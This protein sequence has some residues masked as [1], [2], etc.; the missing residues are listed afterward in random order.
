MTT[1]AFGDMRARAAD[2]KCFYIIDR[3]VARV[4]AEPFGAILDGDRVFLLD[5]V[6]QRKTMRTAQLFIDFLLKGNF[7]R[8]DVIIAVGG[9]ITQDICS[10]VSSMMFRGVDWVFYPTTLLAQADSCIGSKNCINTGGFKNQL[11]SFWPPREVVI[12]TLFTRSLPPEDI[13]SGLGEIIKFFVIDGVKSLELIEK[14]YDRSQQDDRCLRRLIRHSLSIKKKTIEIDEFDAGIRNI[15][16]YGHTF[17]HAIE[18]LSRYRV[19]HGQAITIGMG[20]AN[21]LSLRLGY[22][23]QKNHDRMSILIRKNSPPYRFPFDREEEYFISLSK[24]KKNVGGNLTCVLIRAPG[25]VF[26][27]SLV[28]DAAFKNIVRDYF[29]GCR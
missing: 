25:K 2:R 14:S 5:A 3:A 11:G 28:M 12:D 16:N 26:R 23:S 24:D 7:K 1:D 10:F 8:N 22:L 19:N 6:E 13:R 27:K 20:L 17:G 4:C 18:S 15:F 29:K 21:Y 9:G